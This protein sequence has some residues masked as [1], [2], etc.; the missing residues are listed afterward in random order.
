MKLFH[1]V[2]QIG[3]WGGESSCDP[4]PGNRVCV[5]VAC[6]RVGER[7][8][9]PGLITPRYGEA[10]PAAPPPPAAAAEAKSVTSLVLIV[11]LYHKF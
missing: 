2:G 3:G 8:G 6:E 5:C 10:A 1:S 11:F 7:S 9:S 4:Q